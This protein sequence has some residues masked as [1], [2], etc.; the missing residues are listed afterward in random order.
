MAD[1]LLEMEFLIEGLDRTPYNAVATWAEGTFEIRDD[2]SAVLTLHLAV[3][4]SSERQMARSAPVRG[5]R[6]A[7]PSAW[8]G[9]RLRR[10]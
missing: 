8:R 2:Q 4:C 5:I 3:G 7:P 10:A 1:D 6:S 9:E